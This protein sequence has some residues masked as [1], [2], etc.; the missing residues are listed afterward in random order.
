MG[1]FAIP[2]SSR[3]LSVLLGQTTESDQGSSAWD[4]IVQLAE[5][6]A[7]VVGSLVTG[8]VSAQMPATPAAI[9]DPQAEY[10]N[11]PGGATVTRAGPRT[12]RS[13]GGTYE[14]A[15]NYPGESG[16]TGASVIP[17]MI[18]IAVLGV[19]GVALITMIKKRKR[20]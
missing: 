20:R 12:S 8:G 13:S 11:L 1:L 5:D 6:A 3:G 18:G 17:W 2:V 15:P 10:E 16:L 4:K 7:R 9:E 19:G 14:E